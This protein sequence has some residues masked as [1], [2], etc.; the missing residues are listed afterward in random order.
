MHVFEAIHYKP[1]KTVSK[2]VLKSG[3]AGIP[4]IYFRGINYNIHELS[5]LQKLIAKVTAHLLL[6]CCCLP[7]YTQYLSVILNSQNIAWIVV[8]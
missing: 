5:L 4:M 2:L 8:P 6:F 7:L 1:R 3:H